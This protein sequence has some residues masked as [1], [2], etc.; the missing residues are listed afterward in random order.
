MAVFRNSQPMDPACVRIPDWL[1]DQM[2]KSPDEQLWAM[3]PDSEVAH[4]RNC[5]IARNVAEDHR[6][7]AL[8][9]GIVI[10]AVGC[11]LSDEVKQRFRASVRGPMM[12]AIQFDI[13][14]ERLV[15]AITGPKSDMMFGAFMS[16]N[17]HF[18]RY[19]ASL[20]LNCREKPLSSDL[21]YS[22]H[23]R[24]AYLLAVSNNEISP[25]FSQEADIAERWDEMVKMHDEYSRYM[26]D[27]RVRFRLSSTEVAMQ[28]FRGKITDQTPQYSVC[29]SLE[30]EKLQDWLNSSNS[31]IMSNVQSG[32]DESATSGFALE[33]FDPIGS[34]PISAQKILP[35]DGGD[36][37]TV[38]SDV[39]PDEIASIVTDA[40]QVQQRFQS[41]SEGATL[42]R[43]ARIQLQKQTGE[44]FRM[45][46]MALAPLW[47]IKMPT[48]TLTWMLMTPLKVSLCLR[49]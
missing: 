18:R 45:M 24:T 16:A 36:D 37:P 34:A 42:E 35:D 39:A 13:S 30:Y 15:S 32:S 29:L 2:R 12:G 38:P 3:V 19:Y 22:R 4:L 8:F 25:L 27:L 46:T 10:K 11:T 17:E 47:M 14:I 41:D 44:A 7:V 28:F 49:Q 33:N 1:K 20:F 9:G 43:E 21:F 5:T 31:E 6:K 40:V 48:P 26:I 23:V